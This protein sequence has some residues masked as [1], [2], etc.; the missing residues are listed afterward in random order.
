MESLDGT[1]CVLCSSIPTTNNLVD[2][3]A[4]TS[5]CANPCVTY[6]KPDTANGNACSCPTS[7]YV[8]SSTFWD[9]DNKRACI[10]FASLTG[11]G[12]STSSGT[13][14]L[15]VKQK[16]LSDLKGFSLNIFCIIRLIWKKLANALAWTRPLIYLLEPRQLTGTSFTVYNISQSA[17]AQKRD[18]TNS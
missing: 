6:A 13:C 4:A 7:S 9:N 1:S 15:Q 3:S 12:A 8:E 5:N 17:G 18:L 16:I 2:S 10:P 14:G 11:V